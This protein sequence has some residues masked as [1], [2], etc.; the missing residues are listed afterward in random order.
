MRYNKSNPNQ[1]LIQ[2]YFTP[3]HFSDF[4]RMMTKRLWIL[5]HFKLQSLFTLLVWLMMRKF[6]VVLFNFHFS[7]TI[8]TSKWETKTFAKFGV[9]LVSMGIVFGILM[10]A[11]SNVG[12]GCWYFTWGIQ[13]RYFAGIFVLLGCITD[14]QERLF[15]N[16]N[17]TESI[18]M[19][20]TK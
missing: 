11:S 19:I 14:F 3:H 16:Q 4:T 8:Y 1:Q 10:T 13:G 20:R 7:Y 9:V 12:W 6:M 5:F 2:L 18:N 17:R 15:W